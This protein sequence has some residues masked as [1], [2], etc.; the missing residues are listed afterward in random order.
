MGRCHGDRLRKKLPLGVGLGRMERVEEGS[1][2][3]PGENT[4][5]WSCV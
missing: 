2:G 4:A 1:E 3:T 5:M